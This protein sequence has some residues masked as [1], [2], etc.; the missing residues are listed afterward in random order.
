[1]RRFV[2][3]VLTFFRSAR[4]DRE[5]EREVAAHLALM[6]QQFRER[7][8]TLEQARRAARL[9]IGGV[10]Q[11]KERHRDARSF[12][13]LEDVRR[14]VPYAFRTFARNPV[15]TAAAAI[16]IAL[17]V[18]VTTAMFSV[19]NAILL[20]PLP[21]DGSERLVRIVENITLPS[22]T[23]PRP[24]RR[25]AMTQDQF[26]EWRNRC[27]TIELM[28]ATAGNPLGSMSTPE[29]RER[30][31]SA[32]VSPA[33]FEMLGTRPM[34]GRTLLA[35]DERPDANTTVISAAAWERFFASDPSVLGRAVEISRT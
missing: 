25:F 7:G 13:W 1:M 27:K 34:I 3:R 24:G 10:E 16:T 33:L 30:I 5:L 8:L 9:A 21:Y 19:V 17:G 18:G 23:G 15:F 31:I 6:E 11:T 29:G 20:Q 26:L 35:E 2:F 28:A 12:P 22:P 4:A 14:D 32:R